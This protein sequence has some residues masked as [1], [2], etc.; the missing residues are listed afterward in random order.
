M[1]RSVST[2]VMKAEENYMKNWVGW[3]SEVA[4]E[5]ELSH[6][7]TEWRTNNKRGTKASHPFKTQ[8]LWDCN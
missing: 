8:A 5:G 2:T 3:Y 7:Y 4:L 1:F 6:T